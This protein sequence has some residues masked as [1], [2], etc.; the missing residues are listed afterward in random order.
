MLETS[1]TPDS[2]PTKENNPNPTNRIAGASESKVLYKN[3]EAGSEHRT[4][5]ECEEIVPIND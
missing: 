3:D 5:L 2:C 1:P 4:T